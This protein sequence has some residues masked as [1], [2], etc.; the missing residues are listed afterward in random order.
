MVD[1]P[2]QLFPQAVEIDPYESISSL[3]KGAYA[4]VDKVQR[5]GKPGVF[6]ARKTIKISGAS[7]ED[8]LKLAS[9]EFQI[10]RRLKHRHI[11][12]VEE[13]YTF[14]DELSIIMA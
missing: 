5:R 4:L 13:L 3:G 1:Q 11:I 8:H 7:H 14:E 9:N 6:F 2:A 10:L 12:R